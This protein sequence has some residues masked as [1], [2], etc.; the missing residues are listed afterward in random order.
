MNRGWSVN[1]Q[2]QTMVLI[3]KPP[4]GVFWIGEGTE[5]HKQLL[6]H[7]FAI[8]SENVTVEQFRRFRAEYEF[9]FRFA[10]TKDCPAIEH[11]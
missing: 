3:P 10:P 9:D 8:S 7:G 6:G 1:G 4:K 11:G 2:G 5:R